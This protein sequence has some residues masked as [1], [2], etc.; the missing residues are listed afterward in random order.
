MH[1]SPKLGELLDGRG[2]ARTLAGQEAQESGA[3]KRLRLVS[4]KHEGPAAGTHDFEPLEFQALLLAHVLDCHEILVRY[5]G[6][7]SVRRPAR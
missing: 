4:D 6:A 3:Q 1:G 5:S 2:G 7:Y